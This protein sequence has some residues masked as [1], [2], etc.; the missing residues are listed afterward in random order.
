MPEP[1]WRLRALSP[2]V[3]VGLTCLV[4]TALGGLVASARHVV[5]HHQGRDERPGLSLDD[6]R[7]AYHGVRTTAPLI[8]AL[9]REHPADVTDDRDLQ[10]TAR[11]QD[12]L[13]QWLAGDRISEDYDNL[14]LGDAAPAEIMAARC[15]ACHSRGATLGEG[16]GERIPLDYWDDVKKVAFS[17]EINPVDLEILTTSMHT[18]AL[19]LVTL[20]LVAGGL[21]LATAWPRRLVQGLIAVMGIALAAD[22]G[23][24]W[25]AR[26]WAGAVWIIVV[27]GG[28]Y[29]AAVALALL[30]VLVDLWRP[31]SEK[32]P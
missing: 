8:I 24:W 13:G 31:A 12:V 26:P 1:S 5:D 10:L 11:E 14:D 19:G 3:R 25:L 18:H 15:L 22:L 9:Q 2:A 29:G 7:G 6:L 17:R 27:G 21:A 32:A 4:L 28:V 30:L 16:V 23:G 20:S